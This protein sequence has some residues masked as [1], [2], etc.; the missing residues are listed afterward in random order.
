MKFTPLL[1]CLCLLLTATSCDPVVSHS[2]GGSGDKF[3]SRGPYRAFVWLRV[4]KERPK[5]MFD[6]EQEPHYLNDPAAQ[7]TL[8]RSRLVLDTAIQQPGIAQ[9]NCLKNVPDKVYW[10][11]KQL[12]VKFLGNS[13]ILEI[14]ISG[15]D[16]DEL[17]KILLAVRL[18]YMDRVVAVDRELDMR[19]RMTLEQAYK[20]SEKI[21]A[22]KRLQLRS[23]EEQIGIPNS[24]MKRLE[25]A[26]KLERINKMQVR[27]DDLR[28]EI[29]RLGA[30]IKILNDRLTATDD[31]DDTATD[32][33]RQSILNK[34]SVVF[35]LKREIAVNKATL[36]QQKQQAGNL[37]ETP[38]II[39]LRSRIE[40]MKQKLAAR[41]TELSPLLD[42]A[43][44]RIPKPSGKHIS[45]DAAQKI[46]EEIDQATLDRDICMAELESLAKPF[47]Q[48]F[49]AM[50]KVCVNHGELAFLRKELDRLLQMYDRMGAQLDEWTIEAQAPQ[51]VQ[52]INEPTVVKVR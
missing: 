50:D 13:E 4:A 41:E 9:L 36:D 42:E 15:N 18:A 10:L 39:E 35:S 33:H 44:R 43:L 23:L 19:R 14:A 52:T 22:R 28:D 7:P 31:K 32:D 34:D 21:I 27:M 2:G 38:E 45:A 20:N 26:F 40:E 11:G 12:D 30:K 16:R 47:H 8:I 48:A 25:N 17:M 51:R 29:S 3:S 1:L 6:V 5:I 24:E 37:D 49:I 46:R